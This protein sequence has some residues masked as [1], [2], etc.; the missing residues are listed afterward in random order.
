MRYVLLVIGCIQLV[1][2]VM[3]MRSL[4]RFTTLARQILAR[5]PDAPW[6]VYTGNLQPL[7]FAIAAAVIGAII[8]A[9]LGWPWV[10]TACFTLVL[11]GEWY[12]GRKLK[13]STGE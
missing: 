12:I 1:M 8:A 7:L 4:R 10:S 11:F 13:H 5:Y 3:Q 6:R 9:W 2:I